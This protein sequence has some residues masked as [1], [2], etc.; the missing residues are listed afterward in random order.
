MFYLSDLL[1]IL[2]RVLENA[3]LLPLAVLFKNYTLPKKFICIEYYIYLESF[4][5]FIDITSRYIFKNNVYIFHLSTLT[6][7][8]LFSAIYYNML[9]HEKA[10][11]FIR[12]GVYVFVF[13]VV[14]DAM[15]I[16]GVF[17][18]LNSYAQAFGSIILVIMALLHIIQISRSS[19]DLLKQPEFFLSVSVLLYFSYTI[20]TYVASNIIYNSGYD[21]ATR[22]KLD[23]IISAP[24]A[25]LYAVHMGL[26]AWMFSFFPL[27]IS[28]LRALPRWL[29]YSRW[30]ARPYK[31]LWQPLNLHQ[32]PTAA[33]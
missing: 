18:D 32:P 26:L 3:P 33:T 9:F 1:N 11:M 12:F 6:T 14:L 28:P 29:H 20:I 19:L 7:V 16:N 15:F 21:V 8:L 22:I 17:T 23:R 30:H 13:V 27:S 5:F 25:V 4:Y 2:N 24:D 31:V 10:K